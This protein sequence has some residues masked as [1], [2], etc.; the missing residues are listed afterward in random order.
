MN[1]PSEKMENHAVKTAT[2]IS[3]GKLILSGEHSVVK[4]APAIAFAIDRFVATHIVPAD[5]PPFKKL[6]FIKT[7]LDLRYHAFIKKSIK[8]N[9]VIEKPEALIAYCVA[10]LKN[11]F[12]ASAADT[13]AKTPADIENNE[14]GFAISTQT[15]LP[16]GCGM[17]SSAALILSI[18][19]AIQGA[20]GFLLSPEATRELAIEA[21]NLIHGKSSGLDIAI[22]QTGGMH[23]FEKGKLTPIP[24]PQ[25]SAD[26]IHTGKPES[27]TGECV[28]QAGLYLTPSKIEAFSKVTQKLEHAITHEDP[29]LLWNAIRENHRLLCEIG[30]VP[31][32]VQ[33]LIQEIESQG[34]SAKICGAGSVTGDNAGVVWVYG[35]H[36][37][38]YQ[39][40]AES[41]QAD[42]MGNVLICPKGAQT[43]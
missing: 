31:E 27:S 16:V 19:H 34:G 1:K 4:G 2:G 37:K 7:S 13:P 29:A 6:D 41:Y 36:E 39:K 3:P 38:I 12:Y 24:C 10:Q 8:I 26:L 40:I 14:P 32:R 23:R 15:N 28:V 21:E 20:F 9:E 18:Y 30:V 17:G 43:C 42:W 25:F 11:Y 22:C 35:N 5:H 33:K